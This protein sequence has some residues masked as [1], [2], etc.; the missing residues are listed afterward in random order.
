MAS[1]KP[2]EKAKA[3]TLARKG[4][5]TKHEQDGGLL[6][7]NRRLQR[8][9]TAIQEL[10]QAR[11]LETIMGVIC[12]AARGLVSADGASF[13]LRDG[14]QCFYAEENAIQPLWKGE[15][16]PMSQC[17]S[18]WVMLNQQPAV[19]ED[20]YAD[21]RVP[22][23][24][25]R[26]TFVKSLAM[27]P[28][29][30]QNSLGAIGN[31][32]AHAHLVTQEEVQLLQTL[33]DAAG[34]AME[35]VRLFDEQTRDLAECKLAQ[36]ALRANEE[37]LSQCQRIAHIGTWSWDLKG[38]I[39]WTDE[40][41]RIYGVLA[42]TF[43]PTRES[44][45]SLIHPEDR[46]AMQR[47]IEVC[48][49]GERPAELEF[50]AVRP[51]GSVCVLSGLG[52]LVYDAQGKPARMSGTV[53]D[54]TARKRAEQSLFESEARFRSIFEYAPLGIAVI[55]ING[56]Y[57]LANP[58]WIR[59][60]G[61]SAKELA[62]MN[63]IDITHPDDRAESLRARASANAGNLDT[64]EL[65]KRYLRKNGEVFWARAIGATLRD[66]RDAVIDRV[67]IIEDITAKMEIER[68]RAD[69]VRIQRQVLVREVHHR[70]KNHLQGVMGLLERHAATDAAASPAIERALTQLNVLATVHGLQSEPS[71]RECNLCM[72]ARAVVETMQPVTGA[73]LNLV[74]PDG[75]MPVEVHIDEVVPLALILN[76]LV[77]NAIKH[78]SPSGGEPAVTIEIGRRGAGAT[79]TVRSEPARLPADFDFAG[80]RT[81]GTGLRLVKSLLPTQGARITFRQASA[82]MVESMLEILP[83]VLR[84]AANAASD[85]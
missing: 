9:V 7:S 74:L 58:A 25:Y 14:D 75:L 81:L 43:N 59:M 40:T 67:M 21:A 17:I 54:I 6:L 3:T 2:D 32:W 56:H 61:Y 83:P 63:A 84:S 13:V 38:P 41:Y 10:A 47:W 20:I 19:I 50:R 8:L 70:I 65:D 66:E 68:R 33:A 78:L 77:T 30:N 42:E 55:G 26:P 5:D 39:Q 48:I 36:A 31:Y 22:A 79:V 35:N 51:D 29:R 53:R 12:S 64:Y 49:A 73:S 46:P 4:V 57:S 1:N 15:R 37:L 44:L 76:E 24:A 62:Q 72:I 34:I 52:E 71:V 11:D 60:I 82:D 69:R 85:T 23:S 45:L 27:V 18:G 80:G 16:F 28:I